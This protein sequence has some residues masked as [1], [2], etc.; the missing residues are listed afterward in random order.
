MIMSGRLLSGVQSKTGLVALSIVVAAVGLLLVQCSPP[1]YEEGCNAYCHE[2][3]GAPQNEI[4]CLD[5]RGALCGVTT[6]ADEHD[7]VMCIDDEVPRCADESPVECNEPTPSECRPYCE[8]S[9]FNEPDR[10]FCMQESSVGE[11]ARCGQAECPGSET[12]ECDGEQPTCSGG[13]PVECT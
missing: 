8:R 10:V 2:L 4:R 12:V 1:N 6:C 13:S 5:R 9:G 7:A 3:R 11:N